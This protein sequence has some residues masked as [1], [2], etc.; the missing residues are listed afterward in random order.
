MSNDTS[1]TDD[2]NIFRTVGGKK[3]LQQKEVLE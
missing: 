3:C 2:Y 1:S